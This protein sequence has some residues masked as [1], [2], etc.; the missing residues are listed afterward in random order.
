MSTSLRERLRLIVLRPS[1]ALGAVV[2]KLKGGH[3]Y[4]YADGS[5]NNWSAYQCVRCGELSRPLGSL[6][7]APSWDEDGYDD[8]WTSRDHEQEARDY[9]HNARWFAR[10][11]FPRWI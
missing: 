4:F 8:H 1:R 10:L 9:A 3:R 6:P 7:N 2:C 11:P 5:W